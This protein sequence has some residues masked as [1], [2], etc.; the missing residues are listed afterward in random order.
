MNEEELVEA[1]EIVLSALETEDDIDVLSLSDEAN[2]AAW[3]LAK[4][5]VRSTFGDD[6]DVS[7][8]HEEDG[9]D[10]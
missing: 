3:I 8:V 5:W 1:E 9:G 2:R 4:A 6:I 10:E 7:I